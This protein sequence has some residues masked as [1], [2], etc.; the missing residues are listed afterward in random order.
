MI[1]WLQETN[2]PKNLLLNCS[3]PHQ[4]REFDSAGNQ[5]EYWGKITGEVVL[6]K[7]F[8]KKLSANFKWRFF[9]SC[10]EGVTRI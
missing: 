7:L 4:L 6:S 2:Q 9:T 10:R 8:D 1:Y 5:S 3:L